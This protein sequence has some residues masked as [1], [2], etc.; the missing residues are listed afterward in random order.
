MLLRSL[1]TYATDELD[2]VKELQNLQTNLIENEKLQQMLLIEWRE[3]DTMIEK[4]QKI[5][6]D[7]IL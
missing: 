4:L 1:Y 7:Q 2:L 6:L 5:L 3:H